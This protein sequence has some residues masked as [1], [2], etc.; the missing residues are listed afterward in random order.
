[1]FLGRDVSVFD[2]TPRK[3]NDKFL[4]GFIFYISYSIQIETE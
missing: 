2:L 4:F 1:M 3:K